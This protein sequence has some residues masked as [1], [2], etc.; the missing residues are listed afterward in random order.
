M[1]HLVL[2]FHERSEYERAKDFFENES[3]F[4]ANEMNDEFKSMTFHENN[5]IDSLELAMTDELTNNDF[6]GFWFGCE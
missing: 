6:D 5:D 3:E 2:F 4:Y 1:G